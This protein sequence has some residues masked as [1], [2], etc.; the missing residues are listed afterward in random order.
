MR[1]DRPDFYRGYRE[2]FGKLSQ[3]Q[4]NGLNFL[5]MAFEGA[6]EW[7][8]LRHI[9]YALATV[10]H[11]TDDTY[12]PISEHGSDAYLSKYWTNPKL[13]KKLGNIEAADA[14]RFKGRGYVQITGRR[15]YTVFGIAHDPDRAL[16]QRPAFEIMTRGMHEGLFTGVGLSDYID[17]ERCD[18]KEARRA[19]NGQDR[20]G[21]IASYAREFEKILRA[22]EG[23]N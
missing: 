20:A 6:C 16:E 5:L 11:E 8:D 7:D 10:K 9:A 21:L 18:Y 1:F 2:V 19:I 14:Q 22:S 3:G 13:R 15:N 23:D 12:E 4:V 17:G